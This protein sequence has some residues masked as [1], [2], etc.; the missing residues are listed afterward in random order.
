MISN[1][2]LNTPVMKAVTGYESNRNTV[3]YCHDAVIHNIE[4]SKSGIN[5]TGI[6]AGV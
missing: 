5:K 3:M 4:Q 2:S 6:R 1:P